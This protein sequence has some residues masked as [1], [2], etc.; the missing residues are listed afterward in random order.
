MLKD[1][2]DNFYIG[3]KFKFKNYV[4]SEQFIIKVGQIAEQEGHHPDI[5]FG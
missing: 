3:K 4:Q 1:S 2:S 5:S